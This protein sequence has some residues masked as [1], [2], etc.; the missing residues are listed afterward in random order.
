[1]KPKDIEIKDNRNKYENLSTAS[2]AYNVLR[3]AG[4]N[5]RTALEVTRL[6]PDSITVSK[7]NEQQKEK[8]LEFTLRK[9]KLLAKVNS[10]NIENGSS[11]SNN[12]MAN[13]NGSN[14]KE[15]ENK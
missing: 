9:E 2:T 8:D 4:M 14:S 3:E 15:S 6:A 12:E 7:L 11:Q 5:D 13:N 1:M 10:N